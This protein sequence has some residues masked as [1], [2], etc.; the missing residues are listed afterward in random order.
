MK[1]CFN[2]TLKYMPS[3]YPP[4]YINQGDSGSIKVVFDIHP[5]EQQLTK[6]WL[7]NCYPKL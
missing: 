6:R 1:L 4:I 2:G 5:S 3:P 7:R